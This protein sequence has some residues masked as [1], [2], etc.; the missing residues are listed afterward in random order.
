MVTDDE[1]TQM[2]PLIGRYKEMIKL[3]D[4][5]CDFLFIDC[6]SST[7]HQFFHP[8]ILVSINSQYKNFINARISSALRFEA[9]DMD[10]LLTVF[11]KASTIKKKF[12]LTHLIYAFGFYNKDMKK[13]LKTKTIDKKISHEL[14]RKS[15]NLIS[16]T[17]RITVPIY[18]DI[19]DSDIYQNVRQE[20]DSVSKINDNS[21]DLESAFLL[22]IEH[23]TDFYNLLSNEIYLDYLEKNMKRLKLTKFDIKNLLMGTTERKIIAREEISGLIAFEEF[24]LDTF[25]SRKKIAEKRRE[26]DENLFFEFISKDENEIECD[27]DITAIAIISY[28]QNVEKMIE[29]FGVEIFKRVPI[30]EMLTHEWV[31]N[32]MPEDCHFPHEW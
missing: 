21:I 11:I 4:I 12:M 2:M 14:E 27:R 23:M 29:R 3:S 25:N 18:S 22:S 20:Y 1:I 26:R 30:P 5:D 9:K 8:G 16:T 13:L 6:E 15:V 19:D 31:L 24:N 7:N 17:N 32:N 28:S 10:K